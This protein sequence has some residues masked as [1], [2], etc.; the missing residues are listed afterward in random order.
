MI[1]PSFPP[2]HP[3]EDN[4][5]QSFV[6]SRNVKSEKNFRGMFSEQTGESTEQQSKVIFPKSCGCLGTEEP[7]HSAGDF[8]PVKLESSQPAICATKHHFPSYN[9]KQTVS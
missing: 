4:I 1:L 8:F 9:R 6:D 2:T 3:F 7:D 5:A